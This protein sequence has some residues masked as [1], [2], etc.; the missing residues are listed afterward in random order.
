MNKIQY[1]K[2]LAIRGIT[3][4]KGITIADAVRRTGGKPSDKEMVKVNEESMK[5][6]AEKWEEEK[7][8]NEALQKLVQ[9]LEKRDKWLSCLE[10]AGVDNWEGYDIAIDMV[11]E[12]S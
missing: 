2:L 4:L 8:K 7:V 9:T 11:D 12:L 5:Y 10:A 1:I 3:E 6:F